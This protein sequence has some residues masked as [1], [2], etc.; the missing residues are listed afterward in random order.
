MAIKH[1]ALNRLDLPAT[2]ASK[3]SGARIRIRSTAFF[4]P[5]GSSV[6]ANRLSGIRSGSYGDPLPFQASCAPPIYRHALNSAMGLPLLDHRHD[7]DL[8]GLGGRHDQGR[9]VR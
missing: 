2:N 5:P 4:K 7:P 6:R 1:K 8:G 3:R 9:G